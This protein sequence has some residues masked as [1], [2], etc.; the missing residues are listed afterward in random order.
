MSNG[1]QRWKQ[2]KRVV[3]G[4]VIAL[5]SI[6]L[7]YFVITTVPDARCGGPFDGIRFQ[8]GECV[9]VT[10]GSFVFD[11]ALAAIQADI[12]AENDWAQAESESSGVALVKVGLLMPIT[13]TAN[14]A[15]N[16][17]VVLSS[18]QGAYVALH[19]SNHTVEFGDPQPLVQLHLA[20]E[21]SVQQGSA[22]AVS[23]L[24]DM[25]DDEVP[26]I[27]VMGPA[28]GTET[29][30]ESVTR[31]SDA[32]IPVITGATTADDLD[33]DSVENLLRTA[34]SNTDF[35]TALRH[36]LDDRPEGELETGILVYDDI[37][38]DTFVTT[39]R[40]AY[41]TQLGDYIEFSDQPFKGQSVEQGGPDVFYP[42]T[43]NICSAEPDM[44]FFAGR[45]PDAEVFIEAL[46]ER[47]CV[48]EHLTVMFVEVGLYPRGEEVL[49]QLETGNLTLL[50]ATGADPGW[51]RGEK[52]APEGFADFHG[53]FQDLVDPDPVSLDNG[54]AITYH[55]SL[56][57][58][59][60]AMRI[61]RPQDEGAPTAAEV[62]ESLL[63][64]NTDNT[65]QGASGTLSFNRNRGGNPGGK[66]VPVI[67]LPY[68]E[69][70]AEN[71]TYITPEE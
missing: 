70:Y 51:A 23:Q 8:E 58:A 29:T 33:N 12:K 39:L 35:A 54:Y 44:V 20:N 36:Y 43:Q 71:Q 16:L 66:Y 56:A 48:A 32:D 40:E 24:V 30:R 22:M 21:G 26:L 31:L 60:R 17:D 25:T 68:S 59:V 69:E 4:T 3:I 42:I 2:R 61:T 53:Y 62:T 46:S 19:R 18:L 7:A 67:P 14:S 10:D 52:A 11:P 6:L 38:Q 41:E 65:V 28:I 15:V 47:V 9:G 49:D 45:A 63:L 1:R 13:T 34:P 50:H 5:G 57:I 27:A 55:D 37:A 64:L